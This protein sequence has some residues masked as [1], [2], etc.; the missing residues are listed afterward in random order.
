MTSLDL[1][2][3]P[4]AASRG[5]RLAAQTAMEL[6]LT[7][8][9]GEQLLLTFVIPILLLVAGSRSDRL[10]G[11]DRPIDVVAPGVLALAILSTSFT[12][13]AIATAFERRYGVLKRLGATPL[14][15]SGLLGG[16]VAA[17]AVLQIGQFVVLGGLALA[18]GWRPTGGA[19]GW[20][21]LVVLGLLATVA[22][23][24]LGLLMAGTL[25]AEATLAGANLVY[26]LLLVG[27]GVLLPLDRYPDAVAEG[28][29]LLPSGA[30]GE[31]LRDAFATGSP[32]TFVVVVLAVWALVAA[33]AA[34]RWFRWE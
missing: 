8:R 3:A 34:G 31:G 21:W 33:A 6:R 7:L 11:G 22:F 19:S 15:R 9:N 5:R 16:K 14:S 23:G 10:V 24:G 2:P 25:R 30:L 32:G 29:K 28:L 18:L 1:S 13:L 17:V 4:G 27:G 20:L 26:V 12:S